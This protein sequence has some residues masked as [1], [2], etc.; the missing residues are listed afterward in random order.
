MVR[1]TVAAVATAALVTLVSP[2]ALVVSAWTGPQAL[3]MGLR[4]GAPTYSFA[5]LAM[6]AGVALTVALLVTVTGVWLGRRRSPITALILFG[7]AALVLLTPAW[8]A[9]AA[10]WAPR[11][12]ALA[13][14]A[15]SIV[16][17]AIAVIVDRRARGGDEEAE[18]AT[19]FAGLAP[20]V[21][22]LVGAYMLVAVVLGLVDTVIPQF[23]RLPWVPEYVAGAPP[24]GAI[25]MATP[26]QNPF[27]APGEGATIHNDA[28][29]TDAYT[30]R[31]LTRPDT[32]Q[33]R[34]L[35][36]GGDCASILW[37]T[38]GRL[39]AVCVSPTEVRAYVLDPRTL[40]PYAE[41]HLADRPL[42]ANALTNF[43]GG[44]YAI[45]DAEQRLVTPLP[46]ARIARFSSELDPVDSF[47]L[48]ERMQADEEITATLPDWTG[49]L[50]FV[51]QRGTVGLLDPMTGRA[52]SI[53]LTG[54]DGSAVDIENSLAVAEGGGAYVVTSVALVRLDIA[55]G[56]PI[57]R[58]SEPYDS[59][60]RRK[61]GQTSRASGTTPTVFHG[62]DY[63]AIADNAEPVANVLVF[64][65][66][67]VTPRMHCSVPVFGEDGS[68]TENSLIALGDDLIVENNYGYSLL[69]VA[70]G[71][72]ST[73]GLARIDVTSTGCATRWSTDEVTIPSLVSKGVAPDGS[74]LTYTKDFSLL[75][76]DA[77]WFTAVDA[78]TG[79]VRWRRLAG[80]GPLLNNHYAAGYIGPDGSA[81]VGTVSGVV[82]L[83]G[84]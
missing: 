61:P 12:L 58:W 33:V 28:W 59:G 51:G 43:S 48:A 55:G 77:W 41:R 83:I 76:T 50:W 66:T 74:I 9:M 15:V 18:T 1:W 73:P 42:V 67:G 6:V 20:A 4:E 39:I 56:V 46:G 21:A 57:V 29:M 5:G 80:I 10:S 30:T 23:P 3:A 52:A 60:T 11:W 26:P 75:G 70:S 34:S 14:C 13:G 45:L 62:G 8:P 25:E 47:A 22:G 82:G 32:A 44:G 54:P 71:R 64:D 35:F 16:A 65:V 7:V 38:R 53:V 78:H 84:D 37:D 81:Y 68:A 79:Q 49:P 63:V 40:R 72:T 31:S 69:E 2:V 36:A 19:R 24:G 17:L 27:L